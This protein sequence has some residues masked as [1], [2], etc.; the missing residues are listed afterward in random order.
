MRC[1]RLDKLVRD[2]V[3]SSMQA[4]GQQVEYH[5][6]NEDEYWE[7]W[8]SKNI[9]EIHEFDPNSPTAL[10]ELA[11]QLEVVR[12]AIIKLGGTEE[13]VADLQAK[14]REKVGSFAGGYFVHTVTLADD[15]PWV[16]YY[17]ADPERFPEI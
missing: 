9:E 1:F 2:G 7:V 16:E 13:Q 3:F 12:Q 5:T 8:R 10:E 11:D 15:D 14:K 6:V 4:M 17:A